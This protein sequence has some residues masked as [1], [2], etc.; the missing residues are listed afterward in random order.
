ME[1]VF[2]PDPG[3]IRLKIAARAVAA[4]A[5]TLTILLLVT[6]GANRNA[7]AAIALGFMIA[8]LSNVV[9]RDQGRGRQ[10]L[11]L[12]LLALP[13]IGAS[14]LASFLSRWPW[15]GEAGFLAV[16]AGVALARKLGPR[17]IALGMVAFICY[18]IGEILHPAVSSTPLLAASV[19]VGLAAS[20]LMRFVVIPEDAR[21]TL[22]HI[23]WHLRRRVT[24]ILA[25]SGRALA[26]DSDRAAQAK[27]MDRELARLN[28]TFATGSEQIDALEDA[29]DADALR[30][31]L[32]AVELA[33]ER[34]VRVA[35]GERPQ[36]RRDDADRLVALAEE[37]RDGR[38]PARRRAPP[39]SEALQRY[40]DAPVGAALDALESALADLPGSL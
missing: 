21:A 29:P 25:E 15:V 24:H 3:L 19:A 13:A 30:H 10:A 17:G 31:R 1:S 6:G 11:T 7:I 38:L 34:V 32:L 27:R 33:A 14:A 5:L 22:R 39:P 28:D 26:Q 12:A 40:R 8:N 23:V 9:V 2:G 37:L 18:F 20:A 36:S 35:S 16:V 4:G